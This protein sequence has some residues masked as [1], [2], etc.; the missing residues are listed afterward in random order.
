MINNVVLV[1]RLTKDPD[2]RY[3]KGGDAVATFTLAV[4]RN[5]TNPNGKRE[6]D[7]INCVIWKKPAET[8]ATYVGKGMMLGITGRIQTRNYQNQQGQRVYVT[9]VVCESYQ[10]FEYRSASVQ[11]NSGNNDSN[12][13]TDHGQP[14]FDKNVDLF[15]GTGSTIDISDDDL[16]F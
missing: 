7:F 12:Q 11:K 16:P 8:V 6:A 10:L 4:N 3:T 13:P 5:F 9:E 2:L 1:G 14:N 15:S